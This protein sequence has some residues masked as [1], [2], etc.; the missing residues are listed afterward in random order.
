MQGP[1]GSMSTA[2]RGRLAALAAAAL[3]AIALLGALAP[4]AAHASGCENSWAKTES[5]SWNVASNWSKKSLPAAGEEVC[6]TAAGTY[7]VELA[8]LEVHLKSLT[9][10]A[11]SG[12]Q[13]L[14]VGSTCGV[15]A[16]LATTNGTAVEAHGA[17]TLTNADGCSNNDTLG[18]SLTNAG[19]ILTEVAHGG[20]RRFEGNLTNTGTIDVNQTS[21]FN[22]ASAAFTNEGALT[23]AE[24]RE[25][26]L[27]NK[28]SLT[29]GAGGKI[30]GVGTGAVTFASGTTYTQGAGT[31]SGSQPVIVD[32]ASLVYTGAGASFVKVRGISS[33]SGDVSSGQSVSVE[34][35]CGEH[36]YLTAPASWS[37]AGAITLT[38]GDGCSNNATLTTSAGIFAN[39]GTILTEV[40]HG[41]KRVLQ[42]NLANTGTITIDQPAEYNLAGSMLANKGTIEVANGSTLSLP[43]GQTVENEAGTIAGG[44]SGVLSQSG[45]TFDESAGR[46]SGTQPVV[47]ANG[48]LNYS[49]AGAS[50]I[51]A[52]GNVTLGGVPGKKGLINKGQTLSIQSTCSQHAVLS[53]GAFTSSG[54]IVLTNGDG[55]SNNATLALAGATLTDLGTVEAQYSHGGARTIEGSLVNEKTVTLLAGVTLKVAGSYSQNKKGTLSPQIAGPSSFGVLAVT[56]TASIA[57]GK[58]KLKQIKPF[59]ATAGEKFTILSSA[60]LTGTFAKVSGQKIKGGGEYKPL[61]GP[62]SVTLEAT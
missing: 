25:L 36:A 47:V 13:T 46:T 34:S 26:A 57:E 24:G 55:C 54:T 60:G 61:Y 10:G 6:I 50:T 14:V 16:L 41:G 12:T 23:V 28:A 2:P 62:S 56:G 3:L 32:D 48:T 21:E 59:L 30:V 33:L 45:G 37:S 17:L 5:G 29:N 43:S 15:N 58:L 11:S 27:S 18:G 52:R 7:T 4:A 42:G 8:G 31:T 19:T 40:A 1:N 38:N 22:G 9:L 44:T 49:G 20:K 35:T 39:S 53:A 51:A